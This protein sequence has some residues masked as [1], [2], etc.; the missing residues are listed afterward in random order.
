MQSK[1]FEFLEHTADLKFRSYGETLDI[2]FMNAAKALFSSILDLD[3]VAVKSEREVE[4]ESD[5]LETLLHDFLS[6]ILF[7]FETGGLVFKEF[8]V[9]I[10]DGEGYKLSAKLR[11]ERFNPRKHAVTTEIKAVTYH[12]MRVEKRGGEWIAEVLCD[13]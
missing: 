12:G 10:E 13:I 8:I 4:L 7:L 6:E 11:G 1:D 9:S 2:C 5:S 3:S